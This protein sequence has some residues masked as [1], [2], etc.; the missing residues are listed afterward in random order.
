MIGKKQKISKF[1]TFDLR[2]SISSSIF[3]VEN[4]NRKSKSY[5]D[6]YKM[7]FE[8][9]IY[10]ILVQNILQTVVLYKIYSFFLNFEKVQKRPVNTK[11]IFLIIYISTYM[12]HNRIWIYGLLLTIIKINKNKLN[13]I[14]FN[15]QI[16]VYKTKLKRTSLNCHCITV[17]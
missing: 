1:L 8:L 15:M 12:N 13:L 17:H 3:V 9:K 6:R 11:S 16:F 2:F 5:K 7:F 4:I 10:Y 14:I